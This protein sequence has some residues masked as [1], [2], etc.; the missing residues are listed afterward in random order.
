MIMETEKVSSLTKLEE[1]SLT[2]SL[3]VHAPFPKDLLTFII[4]AIKM[5]TLINRGALSSIHLSIL[6]KKSLKKVLPGL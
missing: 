6:L 2:H 4:L 3:V 1:I 5:V